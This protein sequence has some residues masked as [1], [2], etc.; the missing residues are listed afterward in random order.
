MHRPS[1]MSPRTALLLALLT[2]AMPL[3]SQTVERWQKTAV[4]KHP[5]LA[6]AGS[7]LNQRFLAIVAEKRKSDPAYFDKPD[8]PL[9]AANAAAEALRAEELATKEK[10][11]VEMKHSEGERARTE[12]IAQWE[13]EWERDKARWVFERLVFGDSEEAIVRKLNLSKLLTNRAGGSARV[14]LSSR[15]RW[16]MGESKFFVD[17]EMKDGL[18]AITFEALPEN[19]GNLDSL[20]HEDWDKLRAAA[21]ERF[22]QPAKSIEYPDAQKLHRGGWTVTDVWERPGCRMKLGLTEDGGK[23]SAILRLSDPA[24][25]PGAD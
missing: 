19:V 22:G 21:V 13:R 11:E 9:R 23:C 3:S 8:W 14:A 10:A 25:L 20:I 18:A 4:Q 1:P 16:I 6:Q 24:R 7:L 15:Y 5:A 17:F 12:E 2:A